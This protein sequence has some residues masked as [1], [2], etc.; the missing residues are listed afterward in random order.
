MTLNP[1]EG[2]VVQPGFATAFTFIGVVPQ[3]SLA[4]PFPSGDSIR[5]SMVPQTGPVDTLLGVPLI[6]NDTIFRY[7]NASGNLLGYTYFIDDETYAWV[8]EVPVP[9]VG[10][11]FWIRTTTA[12]TWNRNFTVW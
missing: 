5:S 4:N 12:R 3:G 11:S 8:P 7:D 9:R 6:N 1:G 2:V 10:Q